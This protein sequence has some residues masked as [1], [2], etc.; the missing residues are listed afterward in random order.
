MF[1]SFFCYPQYP[2]MK[3][4]MSED[5]PDMYDARMQD[6]YTNAAV[7]AKVNKI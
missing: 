2:A 3:W 1:I 5:D 7:G 4:L 6:W